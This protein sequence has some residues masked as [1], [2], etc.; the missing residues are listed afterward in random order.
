VKIR[1]YR[2]ELGEIEARLSSQEGVKQAVVLAREDEP[3]DRRLVAYYTGEAEMRAVREALLGVLPEYMVPAAYVRVETLPLMV[4]GKVDRKAL[5]RP[6]GGGSWRQY[7]APRGEVETKLAQI[8]SDVLKVE[9]VGREANFFELGGHS[10]LAVTLVD[11][12]RQVGLHVDVRELFTAPT[13]GELAA[14]LSSE[15]SEVAVPPNLIP[16]GAS[17][18]T[19]EMLPLVSLRQEQIDGI[20]GRVAGGAGNVQDIYP[21]A[22]LQE[23]ILFHHLLSKEGDTYLLPSLLGFATRKGLERFVSTLEVVIGRH[24]ILRTCVMWED[25]EEPVQVV[26]REAKLKVETVDCREGD[27]AEELKR[28]FGPG[29]YRI[30][31]REA[32]L[33]RGFVAHDARADK[34]LLLMLAHHLV[35]DHA[36]LELLVAETQM[37]EQGRVA[38]LSTPVPFRDFVAQAR[39]G[40]SREEHEAFFR[41]QLGDI[42]EP[43]APFGLLDIRDG[44][45]EIVESRK[46]LERSTARAVRECARSVGVSAASVMHLA[47]ALVLARLSNRQDVVFGTV[48]LGRLQAGASADRVFGMFINTLPVRIRLD[49][50][51][52][53]ETLLETHDLLGRLIRH[54]HAPLTLA[55]RC[56][57]VPAQTPLF[58]ALLNYR[59]ASTPA[60]VAEETAVEPEKRI[61]MLWGEERTNYPVTLFVDDLGEDFMLTAQVSASIDPESVCEFM[62][63]AIVNLLEALEQI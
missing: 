6:E 11:R 47:W 49:E 17:R 58:S 63:T 29:H 30:D 34:W 8:W 10:L 52:P 28:R 23:G 37:I 46:M 24:D 16:G 50:Q 4:N 18:I 38:E 57:G 61:E 44:R 62:K 14:T 1:G 55:Q 5:P 48:M 60:S 54:E 20:V 53:L 59:Y 40:V 7:E 22:P 12:M 42:D 56:S 43:T 33:M 19:P 36:T 51:G 32:P 25:L 9:R 39:L 27:V 35:L 2:I 31:V 3:G 15:S 41:E 21:L 26:L 13:L 45:A